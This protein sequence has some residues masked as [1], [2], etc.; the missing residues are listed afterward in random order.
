MV[1]LLAK[2]GLGRGESPPPEYDLVDDDLSDPWS[3]TDSALEESDGPTWSG[4]YMESII[5][6]VYGAREAPS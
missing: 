3:D 4:G 1:V 6:V 2:E 5:C